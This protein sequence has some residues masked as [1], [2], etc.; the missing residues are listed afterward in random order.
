MLGLSF[1]FT[2]FLV[3][4]HVYHIGILDFVVC[5]LR[6]AFKDAGETISFS[7]CYAKARRAFNSLPFSS[8]RKKDYK[9]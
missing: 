9:N 5:G 8:V 7:F 4:C 6:P 1:L 2:S 3:Y